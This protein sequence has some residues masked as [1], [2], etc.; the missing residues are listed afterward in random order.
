MVARYEALTTPGWGSKLAQLSSN[1]AIETPA[2]SS[3]AAVLVWVSS[4]PKISDCVVA[5]CAAAVLAEAVPAKARLRAMAPATT[6]PA[7]ASGRVRLTAAAAPG[8]G[9][10]ALLDFPRGAMA[11][12]LSG[13][14]FSYG[15][16]ICFFL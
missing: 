5:E 4:V 9:L 7:R 12:R 11:I 3:F 2:W 8:R 14:R 1:M 6:A 10:V 13:S 16:T 15:S